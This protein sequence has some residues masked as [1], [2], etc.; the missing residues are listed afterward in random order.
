MC[1]RSTAADERQRIAISDEGVSMD[2]GDGRW[3]R[4]DNGMMA[5]V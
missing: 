3:L 1:Q 4:R 2:D 5:A